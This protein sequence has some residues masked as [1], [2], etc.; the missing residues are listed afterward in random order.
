VTDSAPSLDIS[1]ERACLDT[2]L[3]IRVRGLPPRGE[4]TLQARQAGPRGGQWESA[5]T[6]AAAADGTVD[7]ARDAPLRGSYRHADPMGLVWSMMPSGAGHAAGPADALAPARLDLSAAIDGGPAAAASCLRLRVPGGL[8]RAE[9]RDHGL[10]GVLYVPDGPPRPGVLLL[11]GAEGGL[12]EDDAALLAAHGYAVLALAYYGVPGLP[13]TLERVP[14]EYF[15]QAAEFLRGCDQVAGRPIAA[16]GASKGGE[17]ALLAAAAFP[18]IRA[19]ASIVGSGVVTQG[20]SQDVLAGS[21]LDI[22]STPV[23]CW[24]YR[25]RELP[26]L[27]HVVTPELERLMAAGAPV[28]LRL[29]FEPALADSRLVAAA[30]I[31]AEHISGPVLLISGTDDQGYGPAFHDIVARRLG[32][33]GRQHPWAHLV[34]EGAGHLIAAPPYR[35]TTVACTPGPGVTL[36]H[37]GTPAA[38][39]RACARTWRR[40]LRFLRAALTDESRA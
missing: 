2:V 31:P 6:F 14:L 36:R 34:H 23:A 30:T 40:V 4:V 19:V 37:G 29:T 11:G 3:H 39:A 16:V 17:A 8:R 38:D 7:L 5:A 33:G 10:A 18:A 13:A 15:G 24:T 22:I 32:G 35:P 12:H 28:S 20:I 27:P 21:F 1:P 25:D 9:V 26:Y